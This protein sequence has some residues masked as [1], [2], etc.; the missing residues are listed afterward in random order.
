MIFLRKLWLIGQFGG[1][2]WGLKRSCVG[3]AGPAD[4]APT[5]RA[6]KTSPKPLDNSHHSMTVIV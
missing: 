4:K 1:F 6:T 5:R 3:R 2:V